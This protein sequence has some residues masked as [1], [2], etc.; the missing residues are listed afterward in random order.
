MNS[1]WWLGLSLILLPVWWHR[2]KRRSTKAVPLATARFLPRAEPKQRRVWR[3]VEVILLLLRCLLIAAVTAWLADLVIA[4]RGDTQLVASKENAG[5]PLRS[6]AAH[7]REFKR[8]AKITISGAA[9]MPASP[10]ALRHA[11]TLTTAPVAGTAPVRHVYIESAQRERWI[12]LF[13]AADGPVSYAIDAAPGP[14]TSLVVWDTEAEPPAQLRAPLWW[15]NKVLPGAGAARKLTWEGLNL[16][17]YES[18]RGRSWQLAP[19]LPAS[20]EQARAMF[21]AWEYLEL[22]VPAYVAP[23]G[24]LPMKQHASAVQPAPV[25]PAPGPLRAALAWLALA[26]FVLERIVAHA[27]KR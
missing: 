16:A 27:G 5:D 15:A 23:G 3:W 8:D 11:V 10:P 24:S 2:Q 12:A 20:V 7:E 25:E 17:V 1:L 18:S 22:G 13:K 26:L 14:A 4:W 21:S 6:L 19:L 9:A